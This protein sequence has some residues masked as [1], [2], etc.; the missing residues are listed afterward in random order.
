MFRKVILWALAWSGVPSALY[1]LA[2]MAI[3][4]VLLAFNGSAW[5]A[6]YFWLLGLTSIV[7]V[8]YIF[9]AALKKTVYKPILICGGL[10]MLEY[11]HYFFLSG[12]I[13]SPFLV[14]YVF[15]YTGVGLIVPFVLRRYGKNRLNYDEG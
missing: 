9:Y 2:G 5:L 1:D 6:L 3:T 13:A 10:M 15:V 14:V 7:F 11:F 12:K 4:V 8:S